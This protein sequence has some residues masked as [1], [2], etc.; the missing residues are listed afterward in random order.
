MTSEIA[1]RAPLRS[2]SG[3]AWRVSHTP[4]V[5]A[6]VKARTTGIDAVAFQA[7]AP[8]RGVPSV[9][10]RAITAAGDLRVGNQ[11]FAHRMGLSL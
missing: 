7:R 2:G 1:H 6:G 5:Q 11:L 3:Q 8:G 10:S 9:L 4:T